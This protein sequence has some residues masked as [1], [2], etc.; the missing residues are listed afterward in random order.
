M[1][2][3]IAS[4]YAFIAQYN[5]VDLPYVE[6]R[7]ESPLMFPLTGARNLLQMNYLE[8]SRT[9][10]PVAIYFANKTLCD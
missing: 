5:L 4:I 7:N 9:G 1:I 10:S 3:F 6:K 8:G 2:S